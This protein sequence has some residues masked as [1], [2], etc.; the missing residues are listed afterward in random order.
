M[1]RADRPELAS[2]VDQLA[3]GVELVIAS[4][5]AGGTLFLAGN[6]GS[7][8][9]ALHIAAEL[10]KSF[11]RPRPLSVDLSNALQ[12]VEGDDSLSSNL[13][14]GLRVVVLGADAVLAS[15]VDNDLGARGLQFA[16]D[17]VVLGRDADCVLLL[18]TSGRSRNI[19]NAAVVAR[20]LDLKVVVLTG[21][22]PSERLVEL[23][24]VVVRAPS[25]S[26]AE[27]QIFHS[28]LYH[29]LCRALEDTFFPPAI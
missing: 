20:A 17:L 16:Q 15:A 4:L 8:A 18:S 3:A 12:R 14:A 23:A 28:A 19:V 10:R 25:T 6:G 11:E 2:A 5:S 29:A 27:I 9:D 13:Q 21:E 1:L 7:M 26:T 24:D 22:H